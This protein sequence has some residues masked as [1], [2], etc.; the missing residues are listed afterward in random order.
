MDEITHVLHG[1]IGFGASAAAVVALMVRKGGSWHRRAG[2][3]FV[4]G[5]TFAALTTWYFMIA[6]PLP[7]AMVSSTLTLYALGMALFAVNARWPGA[8]RWEW[9]LFALL[10]LVMLGMLATA[11][12]LYRA[13]SNLFPAPLAMFAVFSVFAVIDLRYLRAEV[14]SGASRVQRHMLM[15]A[16]AVAQM[17]MAPTIIV[18]PDI[19]VPTAVIVFGSLLLVPLIYFGFGGAARRAAARAVAADTV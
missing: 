6:R 7:L 18:A 1:A 13:G 3:A 11:A 4:A 14:I 8:R 2:W 19:G 9:G 15:M 17:V 12:N 10:A 16:L 5:M